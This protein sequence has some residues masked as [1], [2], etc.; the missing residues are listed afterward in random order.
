MVVFTLRG[1]IYS[2]EDFH[3]DY[4]DLHDQSCIIREF[5][6]KLEVSQSFRTAASNQNCLESIV[7]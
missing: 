3:G 1:V 6:Y 7:G 4:D 2:A 5:D